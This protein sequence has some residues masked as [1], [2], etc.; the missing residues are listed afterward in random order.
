MRAVAAPPKRRYT[1]EAPPKPAPAEKPRRHPSA[2]TIRK[3]VVTLRTAWNWGW[4]QLGLAEPFPGT[5]L[6]FAK[7]AEALPFMT[8]DGA[9]RRVA[10]GD[11]PDA[12]WDGVYLRPAEVAEL[13]A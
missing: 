1:R 8:W 13:L 6:D 10:A 9:E 11:D 12:V 5:G 7:T 2:A 3:E 4:R